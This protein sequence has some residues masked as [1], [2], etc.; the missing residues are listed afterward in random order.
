MVGLNIPR[1]IQQHKL[2]LLTDGVEV[3]TSWVSAYF[4]RNF[5]CT[6]WMMPN[7]LITQGS[8]RIPF[9]TGDVAWFSR[10]LQVNPRDCHVGS[11]CPRSSD[12]D[13]VEGKKS[14]KLSG[15]LSPVTVLGCCRRAKV[16]PILILVGLNGSLV[17]L[18]S[19]LR[20]GYDF[21]KR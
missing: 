17:L 9:A 11:G 18:R 6:V 19:L 1:G 3:G 15:S 7:H 4:I 21:T 16:G 20:T 8:T 2:G 12:D 14:L 5:T 13:S 10:N